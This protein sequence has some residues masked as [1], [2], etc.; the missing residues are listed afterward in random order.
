MNGIEIGKCNTDLYTINTK[1]DVVRMAGRANF[2]L[3]SKELIQRR[4]IT[5]QTFSV[6]L[7]RKMSENS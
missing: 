2:H 1:K 4:L 6:P 3:L 5:E 7:N